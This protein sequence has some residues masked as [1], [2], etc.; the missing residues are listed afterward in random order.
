MLDPINSSNWPRD[1]SGYVFLARL[2]QDEEDEE[3][4]TEGNDE[5][6]DDAEEDDGD[7]LSIQFQQL[8]KAEL[9]KEEPDRLA[10]EAKKREMRNTVAEE[11]AEQLELGNLVAATRPKSGGKFSVMESHD[12]N[13]DNRNIR[14]YSCRT[15]HDTWIFLDRNS[16]K[17]YLD[18]FP[19]SLDSKD[20][21]S[22][23]SSRSDSIATAPKPSLRPQIV[24]ILDLPNA[25]KEAVTMEA[26]LAVFGNP[27]DVRGIK[28]RGRNEKIRSWL[29]DHGKDSVHDSTIG[30]ALRK[31]RKSA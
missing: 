28:W 20:L 5:E 13:G 10:F 14:I 25:H 2:A 21:N 29:K 15:S 19:E 16:L 4:E 11:I 12:W 22:A 26:I 23:K 3:K 9:D 30:R 7:Q 24:E 17:A 31:L 18:C 1:S 8:E 6:D 27:P